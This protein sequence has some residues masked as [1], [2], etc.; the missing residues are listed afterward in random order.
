MQVGLREERKKQSHREGTRR[1]NEGGKKRKPGH[2]AG[3]IQR[4]V[5]NEL[6]KCSRKWGEG[7]REEE[8]GREWERKGGGEAKVSVWRGFGNILQG[9]LMAILKTLLLRNDRN[10]VYRGRLCSHTHTG[11]HTAKHSLITH[12][13]RHTHAKPIKCELVQH[14]LCK[15]QLPPAQTNCISSSPARTMGPFTLSCCR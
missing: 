9:T 10:V 11:A 2:S 1:R 15:Y 13:H 7:T 12:S 8:R 14:L 6:N 3:N 4:I 5:F